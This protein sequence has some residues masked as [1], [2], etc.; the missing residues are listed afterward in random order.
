M[1]SPLCCSKAMELRW[2]DNQGINNS[3]WFQCGYCGN[4]ETRFKLGSNGEQ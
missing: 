2:V 4:I 1:K 3:L